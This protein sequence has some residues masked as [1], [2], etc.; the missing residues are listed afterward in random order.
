MFY[1]AYTS[2]FLA[3]RCDASPRA[4]PSLS[5]PSP[6]IGQLVVLDGLVDEALCRD[7][8]DLVTEPGWATAAGK[9]TPNQ[10]NR[11][12]NSNEEEAEEEEEEKEEELVREGPPESK[13]ERG[14]TD[15]DLDDDDEEEAEEDGGGRGAGPGSWGLTEDAM[16]WLC[17]DGKHP[18]IVEVRRDWLLWPVLGVGTVGFCGDS[19]GDPILLAV[20]PHQSSCLAE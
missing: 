10:H 3:F 7:L 14:L 19:E 11:N 18:A 6:E 2:F 20:L 17:R 12:S 16:E 5:P 13:W 4:P 8:L 1:A 9:S 15:V